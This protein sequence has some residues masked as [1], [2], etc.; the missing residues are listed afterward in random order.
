ME[1]INELM[2]ELYETPEY[3]EWLAERDTEAME[4]EVAEYEADE[5]DMEEYEA[6]FLG[7][8]QMIAEA[9]ARDCDEY[10]L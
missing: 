7:M 4:H 2:N 1:N 8:A 10:M 9:T 3:R 5:I 6:F